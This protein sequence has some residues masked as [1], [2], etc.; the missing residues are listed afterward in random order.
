[1]VVAAF[2]EEYRRPFQPSAV[3][4]AHGSVARAGVDDHRLAVLVIGDEGLAVDLEYDL[5]AVGA[6]LAANPDVVVAIGAVEGDAVEAAVA[7][8]EEGRQA[9]GGNRVFHDVVAGARVNLNRLDAGVAFP[10]RHLQT[11]YPRR[12]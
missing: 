1:M 2:A 11:R 4:Q 6:E 12:A 9:A 7:V 3:V 8:E 5:G 10:L